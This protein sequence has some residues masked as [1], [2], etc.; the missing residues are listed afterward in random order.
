[1]LKE[2]DKVIFAGKI[3]TLK[4][5]DTWFNKWEFEELSI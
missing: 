1:M 3:L 4:Y 2:G 5:Y